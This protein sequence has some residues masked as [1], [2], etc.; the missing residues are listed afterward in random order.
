MHVANK[1]RWYDDYPD[2][3][4]LLEKLKGLEKQE[5][6]RLIFNIKDLIIEICF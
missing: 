1:H 6:D 2:L 5:R 4:V 3:K